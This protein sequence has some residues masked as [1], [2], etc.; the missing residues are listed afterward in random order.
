MDFMIFQDRDCTVMNCNEMQNS[1]EANGKAFSNAQHC[2]RAARSLYFCCKGRAV[3]K[4]GSILR[5]C[6]QF[7]QKVN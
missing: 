3:I 7:S 2:C 6:L 5:L 1:A 4:T